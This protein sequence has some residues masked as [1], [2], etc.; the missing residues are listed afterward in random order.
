MYK[1]G[2]MGTVVLVCI[3]NAISLCS[4]RTNIYPHSPT[5]AHTHAL[6]AMPGQCDASEFANH[7]LKMAMHLKALLLEDVREGTAVC[8]CVCVCVCVPRS[9]LLHKDVTRGHI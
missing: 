1:G 2:V 9:I 4:T 3:W 5:H 8:M 6:Q 7:F